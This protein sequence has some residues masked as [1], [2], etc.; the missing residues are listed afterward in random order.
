MNDSSLGRLLGAL[1]SPGATFRSIAARPTWAVPFV[2]MVALSLV[3]GYLVLDRIDYEQLLHQ[4]NEKSGQMT[5]EQMDQQATRLHNMTPALA[6]AQSLLVSPALFLFIALLFWVGFRLVGSEMTYKA[7]LSTSLHALLPSAVASLL[8][9]PVILQRKSLTVAESRAGGF[10]AS[11]LAALA[12]EG[13]GAALRALLGSMD[14][15]NVW[16]V[17]LLLIG[18]GAV[19]KVSR[20]ATTAVVVTLAVAALALKILLAALTS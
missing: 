4:Q 19:A 16:V 14:L 13:T 18:Y 6:A 8:T 17:A 3:L 10:L 5:A 1:V 11:N 15:F 2:L 9:I 20:T 7:S 12:P